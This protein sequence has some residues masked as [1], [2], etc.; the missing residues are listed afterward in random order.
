MQRILL[1]E[2]EAAIREAEAAYLRSAG[3]E[4]LEVADGTA[5][6]EAFERVAPHAVVLDLSLPGVDGLEVCRSLR[7]CSHVPIMMV[8]A[9]TGEID[10]LLGL[11]LGADDYLKKPFN[12]RLLV[13]RV[14]ALLRRAGA[15]PLKVGRFVVEPDKLLVLKDS[16]PIA[17]TTTQFN[18][19][20]RLLAHPGLVLSREQ[21]LDAAHEHDPG[22]REVFDR[23]IDAHIKAIRKRIEDEPAR[24]RYIQTVIGRGY[25]FVEQAD[26]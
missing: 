1:V 24:P 9:R 17:L 13:A 8:T 3:Y 18:I 19:F 6:L 5:A 2:D 23:T 11:E 26:A 15:R 22:R 16:Q 4:V 7:R 20:Y 21:L 25:R 14:Q 12:P 10:E